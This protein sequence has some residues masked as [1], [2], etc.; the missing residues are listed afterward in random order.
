MTQTGLFP[1]DDRL[2]ELSEFGEPFETLGKTMDFERFQST[3][4]CASSNWRNPIGGYPAL[5]GMG[6]A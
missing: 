3:L 5:D 2:T 1:V 6:S 4:D